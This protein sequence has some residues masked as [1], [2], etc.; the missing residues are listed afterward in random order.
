MKN[1]IRA[2]ILF[3]WLTVAMAAAADPLVGDSWDVSVF[4]IDDFVTEDPDGKG[5]LPSRYIDH[6]ASPFWDEDLE[7]VYATF[8]FHS[9][10]VL[11]ELWWDEDDQEQVDYWTWTYRV[12]DP[13]NPDL[14]EVKQPFAFPVALFDPYYI[15]EYDYGEEGIEHEYLVYD[16]TFAG[17]LMFTLY[18]LSGDALVERSV[19]ALY[20]SDGT[21][22]TGNVSL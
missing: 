13:E 2:A 22:E 5:G 12:P 9:D 11:E 1:R 7:L 19:L 6:Y 10:G 16:G 18:I 8:T 3:V 17:Y 4:S 15:I 21:D 14:V 20:P